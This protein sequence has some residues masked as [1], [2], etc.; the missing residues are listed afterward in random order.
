MMK[1]YILAWSV[2]LSV[3]AGA[4]FAQ[5]QRAIDQTEHLQLITNGSVFVSGE[6]ILFKIG[7]FNSTPS[8]N[9]ALSTVAYVEIIN[10]A[11]KSAVQHKLLLI[12]G[13][14]SGEIVL[15]FYLESGN[16]SIIAYT[17]WMRNFP[18]AYFQRQEITIVNPLKPSDKPN[19][20]DQTRKPEIIF[21]HDG[22]YPV[23]TKAVNVG[24]RILGSDK[25]IIS[26][27][28]I[29]E[30]EEVV[31]ELKQL[32]PTSGNFVYTPESGKR[33]QLNVSFDG[34]STLYDIPPANGVQI[35]L[36]ESEEN[37]IIRIAHLPMT[38]QKLSFD[39]LRNGLATQ[40]V[41]KPQHISSNETAIE[42]SKDSL[43]AAIYS[44]VVRDS[45]G[46]VAQRNFFNRKSSIA[47]KVRPDQR[48]HVTRDKVLL[49]V[50]LP[51][52][53][54]VAA[55]LN[56]RLLDSAEI[57]TRNRLVSGRNVRALDLLRDFATPG[58]QHDDLSMSGQPARP[59]QTKEIKF[60]PDLRGQLL[61]GRIMEAG[62]D[63]P[64][65]G[66]NV[67]ITAKDDGGY[68]FAA[69]SNDDGYFYSN[70]LTYQP[71][72]ELWLSASPDVTKEF[73]VITVPEFME[74][75][76]Q[77]A[78]DPFRPDSALEKSLRNRIVYS[79]I[80]QAYAESDPQLK[81]KSTAANFFGE[82]DK[83]YML[84]DFTRF[85]TMEDIFREFIPEVVVKKRLGSYSL[86]LIN[87][88]NARRHQSSPLM[89][90]DGFP[91]FDTNQLMQYD[92]AR[93]ES[94]EIVSRQYMYSSL[95]MDGVL[96]LKTY[97]GDGGGLTFQNAKLL[98]HTPFK[99]IRYKNGP[100]YSNEEI[101]L[102]KIPDYRIQLYWNAELPVA[103]ESEVQFY[104][105]DVEGDFV[106]E[107]IALTKH[108]ELIYDSTIITVENEGTNQK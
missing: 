101:D 103:G 81:L 49:R 25:P 82:P 16:Y 68:V 42:F 37:F 34:G 27:C 36:E 51:E 6:S 84:D 75:P 26:A 93:V 52:Q 66:A 105:S 77:F 65:T 35:N 61:A 32:T 69:R 28:V 5:D 18:A 2:F 54:V 55:T 59:N 89:L 91:I 48:R 11:G 53:D 56:V 58:R 99:S 44:F 45:N 1:I 80:Q 107:L 94:I 46:I 106:C 76:N 50:A 3:S 71:L 39:L 102:D 74:Q 23:A 41:I 67:F 22:A 79:Q 33:Y 83:V 108:G 31:A 15:P 40:G 85:P 38:E 70:T 87:S 12:D 92:P 20:T 96:S 60:L 13:K 64:V 90:I 78:P 29:D 104:T 57:Q 10:D 9:K 7:I 62:T 19:L 43:Y 21:S 73:N 14:G 97:K 8:E 30:A 72:G 63:N 98:P 24:F 86:V 95:E 17:R 4:L 88:Q 47:A 100:D